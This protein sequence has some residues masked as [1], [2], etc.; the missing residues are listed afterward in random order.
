MPAPDIRAAG[1]VVWRLRKG[2]VEV[3][4]IHRPRYDDWSLPKGKL[5]EGESELGCAVR[6][7]GEELGSHVAVSRR[8]GTTTYDTAMGSKSATY[9][10]MRELDG[11]FVPSDEVDA[12]EWLRPKAARDRLTYDFDRRVMSDFIAVPIP[13]SLILLV[14][15]GKA[16]KRAEWRGDDQSRPLEPAGEAQAV[17]LAELLMLFCPD[18]IMSAEPV[19]CVETMQPLAERIGVPTRIDAAFGDKSFAAWPAASEDALMALAK[20]G[21]V[22]AV[23]SQGVTIPNLID[24]LGRGVLESDTRKGAFWALSVVDGT[25]VS[26]DYYEDALR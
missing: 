6:E 21:K 4:I 9:W 14:R 15:H 5:E 1:G 23:C 3:A 18:R 13:D 19:R 2:R 24:R 10:V 8:I 25:V 12:V 11:A 26:M 16:G 22:T 20:P 17:R 7:V